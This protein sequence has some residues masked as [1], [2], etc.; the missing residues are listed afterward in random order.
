[1]PTADGKTVDVFRVGPGTSS[2]EVAD[3]KT[4]VSGGKVAL[5]ATAD[6]YYV[7][8]INGAGHGP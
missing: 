4:S 6:T 8:K 2:G 7:L 1:V 5:Q 3:P